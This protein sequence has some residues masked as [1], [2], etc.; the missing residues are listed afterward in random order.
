M[1][2]TVAREPKSARQTPAPLPGMGAIPHAGGVAFRVWAPHAEKV[3]VIG[4]FNDWKADAHPMTRESDDGFWYADVPAAKIGDQYRYHLDTPFGQFSRI[5][6]YAREVTNSVGNGVVHDPHFEWGEKYLP[7]P[8]WNEWVIYELHVGTFNDT[9]PD[10]DKPATF[11]DVI[12]R[13]DHLKRLGVNCLQVMPVAE[14]A[15]DRSWGYNPAHMFAVES[16]Y[17][18]PKAFKEFVKAAH[19]NGFA[20]ILDVVYNHFGPSDLDLWRFDGW[21]EQDGGGIYFY[22]DWRRSTPWGDT[23]PDYGRPQVRQFI[24]DNALMWVEDY[25]VDGLRMDMTLYVRS[26]RADGEPN[27]PDGW[28]L[29]QWINGEVRAKHPNTLTVAEDLQKS[30][31]L[32]KTVGEGGAGFGAQWDDQFVHP[33]REAV[34][35]PDDAHRSMVKVAHAISHRYNGDAFQRVIYSESHDEVANGRARVP[36]EIDPAGAANYFAQK[37]STLAAALV[38]TSPGIPML[39]QGQE[40][41]EGGWF[42]DTVPVDWDKQAE[43]RGI[44]RMYRDLIRLRLNRD[45]HA[46]G[47]C[48][49]HVRV[50]HVHDDMNM[51][52]FHR[53][54]RGGPFD[55]VIVVANFH[56]EPRMS[57]TVGFPS[58]GAWKLLF[59]SDWK[60][61]SQQFADFASSDVTAVPGEYDGHPARGSFDIGP[62]SVLIYGRSE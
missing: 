5:D 16:S 9:E 52:A 25:H 39:F 47:L 53:W 3:S 45:G 44:V 57:Y 40:F 21:S 55:D 7:T 32:T 41:L 62:Y 54:D 59:N 22:Q 19:K 2:T 4:A 34:I 30:D 56:H 33:V 23:R 51:I 17:G 24:R 38:F 18:G 48:G 8:P 31:W 1:P 14:F 60:G 12:R 49:Q 58:A 15:G 6:P 46:R 50:S 11:T 28:S 35:A 42:R 27:L 20:V 61:Y 36:H 13:F 10:V 37:R 26:V 29:L 43:F